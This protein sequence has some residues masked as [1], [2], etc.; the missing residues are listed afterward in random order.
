MS[1]KF[2]V[3]RWQIQLFYEIKL[4]ARRITIVS[5]CGGGLQSIDMYAL[6]R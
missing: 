3:D 5:A 2:T 4:T 1:V 6:S